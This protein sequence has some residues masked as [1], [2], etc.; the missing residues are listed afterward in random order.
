[1]KGIP[2]ILKEEFWNQLHINLFVLILRVEL[3]DAA[4]LEYRKEKSRLER[5]DSPFDL[6]SESIHLSRD[7]PFQYSSRVASRH[8][9]RK[10]GTIEKSREKLPEKL[11]I[12]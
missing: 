2:E 9:I 1:M 6:H 8:S 10:M 5:D 12:P 4:R 11:G 7:F 3:C